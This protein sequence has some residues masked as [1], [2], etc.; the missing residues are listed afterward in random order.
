MPM[1]S[2]WWHWSTVW[3]MMGMGGWTI[4]WS[5]MRAVVW[6]ASVSAM[7]TIIDHNRLLLLNHNCFWLRLLG[8]SYITSHNKQ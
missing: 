2:M 7:A 6:T 4:V 8:R 1:T 3:L 5:A